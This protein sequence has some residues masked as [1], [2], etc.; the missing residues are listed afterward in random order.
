MEFGSEEQSFPE[1]EESLKVF[2]EYLTDYLELD[3][4][5][6]VFDTKA[7]L[8]EG[9]LGEVYGFGSKDY[10]Q[11][12][13]FVDF[14]RGR[15][16]FT[17]GDADDALK[18]LDNAYDVFASL[19]DDEESDDEEL[20]LNRLFA[21]RA[22]LAEGSIL[23]Y[24]GDK[25]RSALSFSTAI[26]HVELILD[27]EMPFDVRNDIYPS[28]E[29]MLDLISSDMSEGICSRHTARMAY[30]FAKKYEL[31]VPYTANAISAAREATLSQEAIYLLGGAEEAVDE[32]ELEQIT[33]ELDLYIRELKQT[34]IGRDIPDPETV[35][36]LELG[37]MSLSMATLKLMAGEYDDALSMFDQAAEFY[38]ESEYMNL[39]AESLSLKA[40][41]LL[42]IGEVMDAEKEADEASVYFYGYFSRGLAST[43][44][45]LNLQKLLTNVYIPLKNGL[46]KTDEVSEL[47]DRFKDV[48]IVINGGEAPVPVKIGNSV[49]ANFVEYDIEQHGKTD[50]YIF[51]PN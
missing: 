33:E 40:V 30:D 27:A 7:E 39:V 26:E 23:H 11:R 22:K 31:L 34:E 41:T 43:E 12:A 10:M 35:K 42:N 4:D 46:N 14:I 44:S 45:V 51:N 2:H 49:L 18:S 47:I 3:E 50:V 15:Y 36:A 24:M 5:R 38:L 20:I 17:A 37:H 25:S 32:E 48:G 1:N 21:F 16:A 19:A 6:P 28:L 9:K 8:V 29:T 13:A